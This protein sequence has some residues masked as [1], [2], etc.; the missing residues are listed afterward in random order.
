MDYPT[1]SIRAPYPS[2]WKDAPKMSISTYF[3][4][5]FQKPK[6]P[7]LIPPSY[8]LYPSNPIEYNLE[9][10]HTKSVDY[11]QIRKLTSKDVHTINSFLSDH[12]YNGSHTSIKHS[13][14]SI[15]LYESLQTNHIYGL[16]LIL[17]N[18]LVGLILARHIGRLGAVPTSLVTELCIHPS[19]R[20][21]GYADILLRTLYSYSVQLHNSKIHFFHIDSIFNA[22]L[23]APLNTKRVYSRKN[24]PLSPLC[25]LQSLTTKHIE[26]V[27]Q[28]LLKEPHSLWIQPVDGTECIKVIETDKCL[29]ILRNLNEINS[30]N[31][32][33]AEI[34][35]TRGNYSD[36]DE[37][38][39]HTPYG[40]FEASHS[41]GSSWKQVGNTLTYAFHLNYGVPS[42]R[43]LLYF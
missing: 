8:G 14:S 13:Y 39:M 42:Q 4:S 18:Q 37:A 11:L 25:T 32:E 33:G 26:T 1:K 36:I 43:S 30:L 34:L 7:E 10:H 27:K 24:T 5:L 35:F 22:P 12:F 3:T 31:Q 6:E 15:Y 17:E 28:S 20:K 29:I 16:K 21:R 19:Y 41:L 40:W 2:F 9:L 23:I 38:L